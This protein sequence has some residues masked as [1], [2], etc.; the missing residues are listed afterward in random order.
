MLR[1]TLLTLVVAT[2]QST[3]GGTVESRE[4]RSVE[5]L[6]EIVGSICK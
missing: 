2:M 6:G 4:R 1:M 3:Q 5:L